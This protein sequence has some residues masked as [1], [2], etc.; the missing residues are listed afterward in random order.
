MAYPTT[1]PVAAVGDVADRGRMVV[2]RHQLDPRVAARR[3]DRGVAN[4]TVDAVDVPQ[5]IAST[6]D[7]TPVVAGSRVILALAVI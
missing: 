3:A 6:A 5:Q 4:G 1:E 7:L 2:D